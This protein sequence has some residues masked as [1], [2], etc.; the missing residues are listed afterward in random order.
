LNYRPEIDGLR[1]IAVVS[2]IL[3]HAKFALFSGGFV[4]VDI[5]F[6]IS[7]YLITTI[8]IDDLENK[9]FSIIGFYERRARRILPALFFVML[10]CVPFAWTLMLHNQLTDFF[11]SIIGVSLFVSNI[12]FWRESGYYD[13]MALEKPLLHTWSLAVEEQFYLIFPIFLLLTF[14]LGRNRVFWIIVILALISFA[15]SE[16]G[17]RNKPTANF[18]LAPTRVWELFAG[19][20]VTFL[21]VRDGSRANN[22]LATLGLCLMAFAIFVFD[23]STPVPSIYTLIPVSGAVLFIMFGTN[24]TFAAKILSGKTVVGVGLI[25]YSAY[26]WHQPLFSFGR[27]ISIHSRL[28]GAI[29]YLIALTFFLAILSWIFVERPF[30]SKS[31]FSRGNIFFMSAGGLLFFSVLGLAGYFQL[32]PYKNIDLQVS[33]VL[34]EK[35]R[36]CALN[37]REFNQNCKVIGSHSA[38]PSTLLLGDSH[39]AAIHSALSDALIKAGESAFYIS[40]SGCTPIRNVAI[41]FKDVFENCI[42]LN[43]FIYGDLL[44]SYKFKNIILASRWTSHWLDSK[45]FDNKEGGVEVFPREFHNVLLTGLSGGTS[46]TDKDII[47]AL[48]MKSFKTISE[49]ANLILVYPIPEAGWNVPKEIHALR[50][51]NQELSEATLST[52]Y[53]LFSQRNS[54][55]NFLFDNALIKHRKVIPERLFC[56]TLATDR[57]VTHI[58]GRPLY[59]DDDH[60]SLYGS[61]L[62]VAEIVKVME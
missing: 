25:S 36:N 30:R 23:E 47:S 44:K 42:S 62:V 24:Q 57:C 18:Y 11:R 20:M 7:G 58:L 35:G 39:A 5:F 26:L 13:P 61:S 59:Y 38:R 15:L 33:P 53:E 45:P 19:A 55:I 27:I 48:F 51:W 22:T 12:I 6:V 16:W 43:E 37:S 1:A 50:L 54:A 14:R 4:G 3:F 40:L 32:I 49:V 29:Y 41:S 17:W 31:R 46:T 2:V 8:L 56:N 52:S 60:L 10:V 28:N 34:A 9:R 21:A